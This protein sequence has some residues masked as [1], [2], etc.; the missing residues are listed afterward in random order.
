LTLFRTPKWKYP[1]PLIDNILEKVLYPTEAT[2]T[3]TATRRP[4]RHQ[5]LAGTKPKGPNLLT[6]PAPL[7]PL[8][9]SSTF[10]FLLRPE[11]LEVK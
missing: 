10:I 1:I 6:R 8:P 2:A 4:I 7:S 5:N 3:A 11:A 9:S